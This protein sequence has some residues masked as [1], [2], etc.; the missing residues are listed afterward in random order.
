M[1][2]QS[3]PLDISPSGGDT[4]AASMASI[5]KQGPSLAANAFA[6][7]LIVRLRDAIPTCPSS[8]HPSG[9]TCAQAVDGRHTL[10]VRR[11]HYLERRENEYHGIVNPSM[12]LGAIP[13]HTIARR[14]DS[15]KF[16]PYSGPGQVRVEYAAGG[17]PGPVEQDLSDYKSCIAGR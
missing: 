12:L 6:A 15:L 8:Q 10:K 7:Q 3:I 14:I 4:S 13:R 1:E 2:A 5:L 16:E 11:G 17:F 9:A